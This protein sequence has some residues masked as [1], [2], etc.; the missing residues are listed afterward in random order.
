[1]GFP[2]III[3]TCIDNELQNVLVGSEQEAGTLGL[4]YGSSGLRAATA[5]GLEGVQFGEESSGVPSRFDIDLEQ[6][7]KH[8]L[9]EV[10]DIE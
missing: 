3:E 4:S 5:G 6:P 8:G 1:M 10:R 9:A 7:E 2:L